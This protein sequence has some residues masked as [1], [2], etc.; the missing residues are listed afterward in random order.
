MPDAWFTDIILLSED[1]YEMVRSFACGEEALD[2]WLHQSSIKDIRS[3]GCTVHICRD[4]KKLPVAFFSLSSTSILSSDLSRSQQGGITG[5]IPAILL[6]KMGVEVSRQGSGYGTAV[7][8][9]AKW[10]A[11]QAS[12]YAAARLLVVD[13]LNVNLISWYEKRGFVSLPGDK[14]RLVCKMSKIE[15]DFVM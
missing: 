10:Y 5:H 13:A 4:N 14:S 6:G 8:N 1:T 9:C 12:K 3:G 2:R 7:L 11:L 15:K